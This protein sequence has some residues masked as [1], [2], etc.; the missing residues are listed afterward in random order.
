M[1]RDS[2][3]SVKNGTPTAVC[4]IFYLVVNVIVAV[5]GVKLEVLLIEDVLAI[6]LHR[7]NLVVRVT[8]LSSVG[9]KIVLVLAEVKATVDELG[10]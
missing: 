5:L 10:A 4:G 6:D 3:V 8:E 2:H 9:I 1:R 7:C